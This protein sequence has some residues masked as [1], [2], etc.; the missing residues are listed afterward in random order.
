MVNIMIKKCKHCGE[1][2]ETNNPQKIYCDRQH[3][4]PCPVC[5]K[6]VAMI[7]NDFSRKPKCC[8]SECSHI[9]RKRNTSTKLCA[10]C[11]KPFRPKSGVQILCN[12]KHFQTC[13]ICGKVFEISNAQILDKVTTCSSKCS[14]EKLR[15]HNVEKY[16]VD[17][18][19]QNEQVKQHFYNSME[20]KYGVKHA[21][22]IP[23]KVIQQQESAYKTNMSRNGVPYACLLPQ[24]M[25]AQGH[26]VSNLNRTFADRIHAVCGYSYQFEKRISDFSYDIYIDKLNTLV[27]IDLTYTHN[28]VG[29]HWN[30]E[31]LSSDYHLNKTKIAED[32]GYRC[33]HV[34][35]WDDLD[36][37]INLLLPKTRVFA[38]NCKIYRLNKSVADKFLNDYHIQKSCKGQLLYLGLVKD[39]EL[40]QVMTF[41]KPR[42]DKK[43]DV[44]LLRLCTRPGYTVVGGASKLF[45]FATSEYGLNNIISYCDRSKFLG[46]VYEKIGMKLI[47]TTPPQE[48]WSRD[49][50]HITA[51]LLRQRG[52]DQLF[53]TNYGKGAS[54]ESLMLENGWLPIYDCGQYVYE[55]N[56]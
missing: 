8:S 12:N 9:L 18:P 7:D 33:I 27:E 44:E 23:E 47:R 41:G 1:A 40:Y 52:Y 16:G 55:F 46:T 48:V 24:C 26:I 34:F 35:D 49:D 5:G 15:R 20:K 36:K 43:H 42:Y 50:E 38:R 30:T 28:V 6:P 39:G 25:E 13:E 54:N 14:K 11:G 17:H 53:R 21:L 51:N 29:N 56:Q 45:S 3:Y 19:M 4:R 10:F 31:G 2:F 22:Q 32:A 37:I